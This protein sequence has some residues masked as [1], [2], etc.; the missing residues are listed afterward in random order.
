MKNI[1]ANRAEYKSPLQTNHIYYPIT[2]IPGE[3]TFTILNDGTAAAPCR[4]SF[5][6]INDIVSCRITGLSEEELIIN[7]IRT[8]SKVVLD[9]INKTITI[10][11]LEAFSQ[12]D[13]W[14][15]PKL[16]PG[17]NKV[18]ITNADSMTLIECEFQPRY[19]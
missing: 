6:P 15:F 17:E 7:N 5:I 11:E 16:Q 8:G 10:N 1:I 3:N 2:V 19:I 4:L 13:G 9:G 12:F 18:F 14:E